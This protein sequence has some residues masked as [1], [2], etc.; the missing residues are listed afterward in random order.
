M[1]LYV[2]NFSAFLLGFISYQM[3]NCWRFCLKQE[4]LTLYSLIYKSA[5]MQ[6]PSECH[7]YSSKPN[8]R[9]FIFE[10]SLPMFLCDEVVPVIRVL[11]RNTGSNAHARRKDS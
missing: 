2:I 9:T 5:L 7:L 11:V 3:M 8:I 10:M 1:L 6:S 4:I